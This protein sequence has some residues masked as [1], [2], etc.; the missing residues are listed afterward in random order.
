VKKAMPSTPQSPRIALVLG[1]GGIKCIASIGLLKVLHREQIIP[2]LIVG[3]SG[4]SLFGAVYAIGEH[5]DR[6][7]NLVLRMWQKKEF[8][9]FKYFDMLK[10]F[11]PKFLRFN[12]SFG[13]IRGNRV[14]DIFR[15]YF[16]GITFEHTK[17]PLQIVTTDFF[18]GETVVLA[19]GSVAEAVRASISIP[20]FFQPKKIAGKVLIDGAVSNPLPI[21]VAIRY[22][23]DIIIAMG[24]ESPIYEIIDSPIT[25]LLHLTALYNNNL[26]MANQAIHNMAHHYEIIMVCPDLPEAIR[27]F[28]IEKIPDLIKIGEEE[29]TQEFLNIRSAIENFGA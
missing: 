5:P 8:R 12:E 15:E 14:E 16:Q 22:G 7:E 28:D 6:I 2:D 17:I 13:L 20:V 9:D 10:M 25:T 1:S 19:E 3:C 23:A 24:Y 4:G 18:T 26:M 29:A 27:F 21:D 11:L